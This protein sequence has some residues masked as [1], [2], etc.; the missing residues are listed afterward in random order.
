MRQS[1]FSVAAIELL[2][3]LAPKYVWWKPPQES[4]DYPQQLLA[5]VMDLGSFEDAALLRNLVP[6]EFLRVA[7]QQAEPGQFRPRSWTYWHLM[8][9]GLVD[10]QVPAEPVRT[11][12]HL[13]SEGIGY[14]VIQQEPSALTVVTQPGRVLLS[15]FGD[16]HFGS[17]LDPVLSDD[18]LLVAASLL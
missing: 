8:L 10:A 17:I 12:R 18:E 9:N 11:F 3:E 4:L 6:D 13:A 2:T 5:S 1:D 7:L 14:G 16:I 15:F